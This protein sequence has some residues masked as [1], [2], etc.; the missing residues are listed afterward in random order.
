V[1]KFSDVEFCHAAL[2]FLEQRGH[3]L[4]NDFG[5][6]EGVAASDPNVAIGCI[7]L[8][9]NFFDLSLENQ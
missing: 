6:H 9:V 1:G 5:V 7:P 3:Q 8:R 4:A 2:S